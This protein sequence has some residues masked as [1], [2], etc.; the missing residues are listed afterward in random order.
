VLHLHRRKRTK[1]KT[2]TIRGTTTLKTLRAFRN[3]LVQ[4]AMLVMKLVDILE[5][6]VANTKT[7]EPF[8]KFLG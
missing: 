2:S 1:E 8:G 7:N 6:L 4:Q 5:E 3:Q